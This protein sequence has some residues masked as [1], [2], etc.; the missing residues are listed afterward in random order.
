MFKKKVLE[1]KGVKINLEKGTLKLPSKALSILKKTIKKGCKDNK[2]GTY[3][4]N[5]GVTYTKYGDKKRCHRNAYIS[6]D[7]LVLPLSADNIKPPKNISLEEIELVEEVEKPEAQLQYVMNFKEGELKKVK[8]IPASG[9]FKYEN[10]IY[11]SIKTGSGCSPRRLPDMKL[12]SSELGERF[13]EMT[14]LEVQELILV[15]DNK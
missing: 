15:T 6:K 4:L 7:Y 8:E 3:I 10:D 2:D 11:V 12:L 13:R 9:F 14:T 5:E 1:V